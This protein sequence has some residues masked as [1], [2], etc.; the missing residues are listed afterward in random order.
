MEG[1]LGHL[2]IQLKH[3]QSS[4]QLCPIDDAFPSVHPPC[5]AHCR[6]QPRLRPDAGDRWEARSDVCSVVNVHSMQ[7]LPGTFETVALRGFPNRLVARLFQGTR[8]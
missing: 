1:C 4:Q 5:P 3:L 6:S 8:R 7:N 2:T